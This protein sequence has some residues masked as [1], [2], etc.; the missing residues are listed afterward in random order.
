MSFAE[1][2][3]SGLIGE[4]EIANWLIRKGYAVLPVYETEQAFKGPRLFSPGG[5]L[6]APDMFV[7]KAGRA[8]WIEAKTKSAFTWHR[9][10]RRW[11]TGID[12]HHY[13]HYLAI[14]KLSDMPIYLMFLHRHG[15]AAKDSPDGCPSGLF[16]GELG[17]LE[18][19]ENHRSPNYGK[20]GMVYWAHGVLSRYATIEEIEA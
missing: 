13:E 10:T 8:R 19:H 1:T 14:M 2:L 4:S 9:I 6:I 11:T 15:L 18:Q 7:F 3:K 5:Q 20:L 16:G 17:Y 12:I